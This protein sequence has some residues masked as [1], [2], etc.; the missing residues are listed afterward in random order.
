[1][2][3]GCLLSK[4]GKESN[5]RYHP[6]DGVGSWRVCGVGSWRVCGIQEGQP[7]AVMDNEFWDT[8]TAF[9]AS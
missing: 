6:S 2:R 1:M 4:Y 7:A 3:L 8:Q 9:W 5:L